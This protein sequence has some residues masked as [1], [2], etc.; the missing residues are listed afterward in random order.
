MSGR[1]YVYVKV[2]ER[3]DEPFARKSCDGQTNKQ[4]NKQTNRRLTE[5][6]KKLVD[7][8]K[9][10]M[11]SIALKSNGMLVEIRKAFVTLTLT[12]DPE[13]LRGHVGHIQ[14]LST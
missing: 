8:D 7:F 9:Q 1:P 6:T 12:L 4:T 14:E 5:Q 11:K 3:L 2:S 10:Q 13:K